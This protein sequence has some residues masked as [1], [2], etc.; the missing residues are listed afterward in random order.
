MSTSKQ[1]VSV[2][3]AYD[4]MAECADAI[5]RSHQKML[6]EE[7]QGLGALV[8]GPDIDPTNDARDISHEFS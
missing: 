1:L 3:R 4:Q 7:C 6:N 2:A 5:A 8:S